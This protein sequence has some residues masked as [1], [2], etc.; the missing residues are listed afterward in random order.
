LERRGSLV[1]LEANDPI[2]DR[3]QAYQF[4]KGFQGYYTAVFDGHGGWQV[5]DHAM[6]HLHL[7]LDEELAKAKSE[8]QIKAAITKAFDRL[9]QDIID[10]ADKPFNMGYAKVAYTGA[11]AL[12]AIVHNDK[13]YVANSGDCKGTILRES[14]DGNSF[15]NVDVSTTFST[16]KKSEQERLKKQWP[17]D[18]NIFICRAER[19]CYVKGGLMPSRAFGDLRLKLKEFNY[20][21]FSPLHGFR[22]PIPDFEGPYITHTPEIKVHQIHPKDKWL[23]LATDGLWDEMKRKDSAKMIAT[24]ESEK[25]RIV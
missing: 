8:S 17:N 2:E 10:M 7:Y 19:A 12:V 1:Q 15:T 9:E 5:A 21:S 24:N 13:V 6:R 18:P 22:K 3:Y 20:H 23:I 14:E 25:D 4:K 11:C 16:N